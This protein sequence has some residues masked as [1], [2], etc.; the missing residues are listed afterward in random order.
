ENIRVISIVDRYLEHS[1]IYFFQN[2]NH[3]EVYLSSAD[4]MPR[5]FHKRLEVAFP[6][7][8][9][10]LKNFLRHTVLE[11]FLRDN[12]KARLLQPDGRWV[13]LEPRPEEIPHHAQKAFEV[14]AADDYKGTPLVSRF[15]IQK[16]ESINIPG[17]A[18]SPVPSTLP[19][20]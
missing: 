1:R 17:V 11:N 13:R 16:D 3:A 15:I 5:N 6:I 12:Q 7:F 18:P 9:I 2:G 8:D 10:D 4:W 19:N 14:L 20:T